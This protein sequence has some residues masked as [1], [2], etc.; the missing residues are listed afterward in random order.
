VISATFYGTKGG[1]AMHNVDG[2]FYDFQAERFLGTKREPL[3]APPDAWG[4]RAAVDWAARLARG[5][6]FDGRSGELITVAEVLDR[7]YER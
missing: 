7:I 5:E 6:G 4:G 3:A 1:A 2:S